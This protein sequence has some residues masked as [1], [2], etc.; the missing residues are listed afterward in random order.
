MCVYIRKEKRKRTCCGKSESET[1]RSNLIVFW[2]LCLLTA[3]SS[4]VS[5]N[6]KTYS[7]GD[8]PSKEYLRVKA[9]VE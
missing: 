2:P 7:S 5:E 3:I 1:V 6:V 4:V 9:E 8:R